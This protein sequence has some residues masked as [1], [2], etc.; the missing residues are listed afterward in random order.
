MFDTVDGIDEARLIDVADAVHREIGAGHR[1]WLT[2]I[3]ELDRRELWRD[4]GARDTAHWLACATASPGGR[5][6]V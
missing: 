4:D 3:A 1:R 2:L 5:R 6:T